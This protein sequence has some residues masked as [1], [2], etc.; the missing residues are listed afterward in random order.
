MQ[1]SIIRKQTKNRIRNLIEL[2]PRSTEDPESAEANYGKQRAEVQHRYM[3]IIYCLT[4]LCLVCLSNFLPPSQAVQASKDTWRRTRFQ[5]M[6]KDT[7][8]GKLIVHNS[9]RWQYN[10]HYDCT[11]QYTIDR[12]GF[13]CPV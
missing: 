4:W 12:L 8:T 5:G 2:T 6:V 11:K 9:F 13:G 1:N 3:R 10:A 7:S